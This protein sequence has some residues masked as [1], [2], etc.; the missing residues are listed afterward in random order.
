MLPRL[1]AENM[2]DHGTAVGLGTGTLKDAG[3][4]TRNLMSVA[5]GDTRPRRSGLNAG[6]LALMGIKVESAHG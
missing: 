2:L 3:E 1:H 6:A 4:V 5:Q